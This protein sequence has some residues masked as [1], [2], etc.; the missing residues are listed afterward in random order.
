MLRPGLS[1]VI[2]LLG[3]DLAL[4]I[5]DAVVTETIFNL[6][7]LGALHPRRR[8]DINDLP[9]AMGVTVIAAVFVTVM[10]LVVDIV[11]AFLDPRVRYRERAPPRCPRPVGPLPDG[12]RDRAGRRRRC[13]SRSTAGETLGVVGRV[14]VGQER[15]LHDRHGAHQPRLRGDRAA[16]SASEGQDLLAHPG[17]RLA[18]DPRRRHRD[19][20]PGPDDLAAPDVPRGRPDRRG[21]PGA[22]RRL[23]GRGVGGWPS[24]CSGWSGSPRPSSASAPTRTS[25][26]AACASAR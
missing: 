21:R 15:H 18:A 20:V 4:L 11:Y 3:I 22:P 1:P 17:P 14:R 7:G 25:S 23:Q 16:R 10:N 5:G 24:K 8:P 12:G 6:P 19:G 9:V 2:T 13:R 26:R